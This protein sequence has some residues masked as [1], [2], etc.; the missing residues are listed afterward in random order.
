M[1]FVRSNVSIKMCPWGH[2][3][4]SEGYRH[5]PPRCPTPSLSSIQYRHVSYKM[6][7]SDCNTCAWAQTEVPQIKSQM[8]KIFK[9]KIKCDCVNG[10]GVRARMLAAV[11]RAGTRIHPQEAN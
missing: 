5:L 11:T 2:P 9:N 8:L 1:F 10:V 3:D 6:E 4:G 7:S